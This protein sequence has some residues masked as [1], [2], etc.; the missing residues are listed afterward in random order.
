MADNN[1]SREQEIRSN[2]HNDGIFGFST[3]SLRNYMDEHMDDLEQGAGI[4]MGAAFA[5]LATPATVGI[6]TAAAGVVGYK[7]GST[8]MRTVSHRVKMFMNESL[9]EEGIE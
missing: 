5:I 2:L 4:A 6:G 3:K 1:I 9:K 7:L 8:M